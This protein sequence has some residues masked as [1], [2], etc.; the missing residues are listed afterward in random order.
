MRAQD[1]IGPVWVA[2]AA[3]FALAAQAQVIP[4]MAGQTPYS[5]VRQTLIAQG[6][7]PV[8]QTQ[9]CGP[10]CSD[11]RR[12]GWTEAHS[13][14]TPGW[15]LVS[16][17]SAMPAASC[18]RWSPAGKVRSSTPTANRLPATEETD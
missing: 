4:Q 7:T 13:V 10:V 18:L 2:S 14:R 16:L 11:H 9:A 15:P 17:C 3:L 5:K 6:W 8:R 1:Y 12:A